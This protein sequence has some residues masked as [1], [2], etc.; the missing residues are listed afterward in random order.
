MPSLRRLVLPVLG[1]LALVAPIPMAQASSHPTTTFEDSAGASWTPH[2]DELA[3]LAAVDAA[4]E[5]VAVDVIG[6]SHEGRPLHLVRIGHPRPRPVEQAREGL[7]QLH[8]CTQHGNEPAGREACLISL[9]DLAF[10]D[11][12]ELVAHLS[13]TTVLFVPTVNP[14]GREANVRTN[15][16]DVDLNR[17]HL[18]VDEPETI[19]VGEVVR[20]WWPD[21]NM[22]HH[23]YGPST[24]ALYDDDLLYLWPRNLNVDPTVRETA[25]TF[26]VE[27]LRPCV[28]E[29]GYS[30]D[31]YGLQAAGD[32]DLQQTAGDGD[33]GISRNAAG[34]RH[35]LGILV[36][37]AVTPNPA[38]PMEL[39]STADNQLRRVVSQVR[40]IDCTIDYLRA[41]GAAVD[42]ATSASRERAAVL[43]TE[44]SEPTY[45]GGQDEDT[46][47]TGGNA[48]PTAVQD[49]PF[50]GFLLDAGVVDETVRTSMDVHAIET[51]DTTDG[52][53]VTMAQQAEPVIGLLYDERGLRHQVAGQ[54]LDD[55]AAFAAPVP[56]AG[57]PANPDDP[58]GA[59]GTGG[60]GLPATGGGAALFALTLLAAAGMTRHR[61]ATR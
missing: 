57:P 4:S 25:K 17:N 58:P 48:E 31:E 34:L 3:F 32:L 9:R 44:R 33:D 29:E 42:A 23:E 14:D 6:Q 46:T 28:E 37:S 5:R 10:T 11:D 51:R 19:A 56:T 18:E 30:A 54:G 12:P 47:V 15:A 7:V 59:P 26:A 20:D 61:R 39:V 24:P 35:G 45:F 43:G 52:V 55:C 40:A 8:V 36:E 49:P 50:C 38:N 21:M 53:F 60:A 1:G 2:E 22:D 16:E 27:H 41:N 13:S